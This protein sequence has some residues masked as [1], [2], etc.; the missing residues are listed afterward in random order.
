MQ[1][2]NITFALPPRSQAEQ[3]QTCTSSK[4]NLSILFQRSHPLPDSR[5]AYSEESMSSPAALASYILRAPPAATLCPLF[6]PFSLPV[7]MSFQRAIA[8]ASL[9]PI[10]LYATVQLRSNSSHYARQACQPPP[11]S[12]SKGA[13]APPCSTERGL[14]WSSARH[15]RGITRL[16]RESTRAK[17]GMRVLRRKRRRR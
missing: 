17:A 11:N 10:R 1:A 6:S 16:H 8:S 7:A 15:L 5:Y 12:H 13:R 4:A 2:S 9:E 3:H 14:I